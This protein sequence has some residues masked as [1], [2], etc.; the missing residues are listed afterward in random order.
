MEDVK[1]IHIVSIQ[2]RVFVMREI[3]SVECLKSRVKRI[4]EIESKA[5]NHYYSGKNEPK[6]IPTAGS[7]DAYHA[8]SDIIFFL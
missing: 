8:S 3:K 7:D 6:E 4:V 1:R 5:L 2:Q